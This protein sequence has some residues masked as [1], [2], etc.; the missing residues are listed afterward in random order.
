MVI[1][2][3]DCAEEG[4]QNIN[5]ESP[6]KNPQYTTVYAGNL[7]PKVSYLDLHRHFY[8]LGAGATEDVRFKVIKAL[9]L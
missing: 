3:L 9:D 8:A 2:L 1:W 7:A 6:E 4:H 5:D